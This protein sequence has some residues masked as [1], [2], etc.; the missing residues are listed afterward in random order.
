MV[1]LVLD[2]SM[3][4]PQ[5]P[6][7]VLVTGF[8]SAYLSQRYALR[9]HPK[10]YEKY[11]KFN[12]QRWSRK[13]SEIDASC[14]DFV[15]SAALDAGTSIQALVVYVLGLGMFPHWWGNSAIDTEHCKPGS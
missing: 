14:V 6:T 15:L 5:I 7:N 1:P 4:A 12:E 10:W 3:S 2:G 9:K 13:F 8:L 11:S